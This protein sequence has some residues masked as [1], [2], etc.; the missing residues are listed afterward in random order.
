MSN[1]QCVWEDVCVIPPEWVPSD[2]SYTHCYKG[3]CVC[4]VGF[5]SETSVSLLVL[6][7]LTFKEA[8]HWMLFCVSGGWWIVF[9]RGLLEILSYWWCQLHRGRNEAPLISQHSSVCHR[10]ISSA[11]T[12]SDS[13]YEPLAV[14]TNQSQISLWYHT[15]HLDW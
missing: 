5:Y 12:S 9:I 15:Y 1:I 11:R 8:L 7:V 13:T 6:W 2:L 3:V 10:F 14:K 4:V